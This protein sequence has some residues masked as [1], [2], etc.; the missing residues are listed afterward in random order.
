MLR[1]QRPEIN[2]IGVFRKDARMQDCKV[3]ITLHPCNLAIL[4]WRLKMKERRIMISQKLF[5]DLFSYFEFEDY[6]K[7]TE[8][9]KALNEKLELLAMHENYTKYKT[10]E[11]EEEREKARQ[12]YLDAKR[13]H[14]SF[15][16]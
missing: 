16:W 15:R 10:A 1:Q 2:G 3:Y 14:P 8:I 5:L 12:E 7:E 11:S 4:I 6:E 13:I 9:R